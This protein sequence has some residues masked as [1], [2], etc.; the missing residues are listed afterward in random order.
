MRTSLVNVLEGEPQGYPGE[1]H[2]AGIEI[3]CSLEIGSSG[4]RFKL[5]EY[6]PLDVLSAGTAY[7]FVWDS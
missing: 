1:L 3:A 7:T 5:P 6:E 4:M 2:M